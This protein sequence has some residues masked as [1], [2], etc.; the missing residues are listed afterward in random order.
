MELN[1]PLCDKFVRDLQS[2]AQSLIGHY[3]L[4][5]KRNAPSA[6]LHDAL[7]RWADF[8]FRYVV[9]R[10][11]QVLRSV[12]FPKKFTT[13]QNAAL[14]KFEVASLSG[15]DLNP[16]QGRGLI[17][18]DDSSGSDTG[19]R[20]DALWADW[21]VH[22]FHLEDAPLESSGYFSKRADDLAFCW[23]LDDAIGL[24][25]VLPHP[26]AQGW[27]CQHLLETVHRSWPDVLR[28][29]RVPRKGATNRRLSDAEIHQLRKNGINYTIEID[30]FVYFSPGL[31]VM[32]SKS[33]LKARIAVD[34]AAEAARVLARIASLPDSA[35]QTTLSTDGIIDPQLS[36]CA[37]QGEIGIAEARS[38]TF[39]H[40]PRDGGCQLSN[41]ARTLS[42]SLFPPWALQ[43]IANGAK[44]TG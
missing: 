31:G 32:S 27:S 2:I 41:A 7:D 24:I 21:G 23:V 35:V 33:S 9:P 15:L 44:G 25:D 16:R 8:R 28:P 39:F 34:H 36:L 19:R 13:K 26:K 3:N 29:F 10:S 12:A 30:G 4:R 42:N 43:A 37:H 11:R 20:S 17:D 22:H 38:S 14:G 40:L 5:W 6:H 1:E 18:F